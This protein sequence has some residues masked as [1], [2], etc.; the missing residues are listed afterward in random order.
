MCGE[1]IIHCQ[2]SG[3]VN[4]YDVKTHLKIRILGKLKNDN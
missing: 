2:N 3:H 4:I 1:L